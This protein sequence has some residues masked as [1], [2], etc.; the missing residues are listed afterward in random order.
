MIIKNEER[1]QERLKEILNKSQEEIDKMDYKEKQNYFK[2]RSKICRVKKS[3][4]TF[5]KVK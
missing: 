3:T 5:R 1:E 4:E 2:E